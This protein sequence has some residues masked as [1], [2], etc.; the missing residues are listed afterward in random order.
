MDHGR[1]KNLHAR[2]DPRPTDELIRLA[3]SE[4]DEDMAWEYVAALQYRGDGEVFQAADRLCTSDLATERELGATIIGQLGLPERTFPSKSFLCLA[5]MLQTE[6]D[7][8][9]LQAIAVGFGHLENPRCIELLTPLKNHPANIVRWGIAHGISGHNDPVAIQTLIELS[10]DEDEEIRDWATFGLGSLIDADSQQIRDAL[11][12]RVTDTFEDARAE[13]LAGLA[14]RKDP[15]VADLLLRELDA[16]QVD[17]MFIDAAEEFADLSLLPVLMKLKV[18][19]PVE[20]V[21]EEQWLDK[22]IQS[23]SGYPEQTPYIP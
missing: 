22:A 6:T 19:W 13:A 1:E 17:I 14:R 20:R 23:C 8:D 7:P 4:P 21:E 5:R 2:V 12:A 9:T 3:L 11:W 10:A 18:R 16:D 15:R